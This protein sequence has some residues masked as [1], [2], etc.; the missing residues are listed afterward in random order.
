M[1]IVHDIDND[2]GTAWQ[3]YCMLTMTMELHVDND[4]CTINNDIGKV[5]KVRSDD[6]KVTDR[7]NPYI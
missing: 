7:D 2:N 4:S 1:I 5:D 3:W 6:G